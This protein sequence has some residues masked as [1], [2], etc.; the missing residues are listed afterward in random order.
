MEQKKPSEI[1]EEY[2]VSAVNENKN[3]Y[4]EPAANCGKWMIFAYTGEQLDAIWEK[5]KKAVK[6]GLLG[7]SAKCSTA[8]ENPN[9]LNKNSGVICIYTYDSNDKGD[10]KRIVEELFKIE[11]VEKLFY[12]EDNATYEGKYAN[13]GDKKISKWFVTKQNFEEVLL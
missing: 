9:A 7:S 1:T 12:K 6:K 10:L 2:W 13:K 3:K 4:P 11:G 8:K 5:V